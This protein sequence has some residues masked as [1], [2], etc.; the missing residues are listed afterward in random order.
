M[1][2]WTRLLAT[3]GEGLEEIRPTYEELLEIMEWLTENKAEGSWKVVI[4]PDKWTD[5]QL[6]KIAYMIEVEDEDED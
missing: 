1:N 5:E 2:K 6:E 4:D 3:D